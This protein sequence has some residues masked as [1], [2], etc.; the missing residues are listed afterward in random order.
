[1]SV[2]SAPPPP[3]VEQV[4]DIVQPYVDSGKLI[5]DYDTR[6]KEAYFL[7]TEESPT[8]FVVYWPPRL[9]KVARLPPAVRVLQTREPCRWHLTT[10]SPAAAASRELCLKVGGAALALAQRTRGMVLDSYDFPI[11]RAEDLVPR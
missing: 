9:T 11:D 5:I 2:F 10:T 6:A 8:F 1:V 3:P 4:I 7:V